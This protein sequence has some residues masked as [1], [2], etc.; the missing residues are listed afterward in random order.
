[1]EGI[2]EA[3]RCLG[4]KN[5]RCSMACPIGTEIPRIIELYKNGNIEKAGKILYE[6]NPL[7]IICSK[8]CPHENNCI[9]N[10]ILGIRGESINFPEIE[11][12]ISSNYLNNLK[13]KISQKNGE[14]IAIIG[15]GPA[16][17][18]IALILSS[19]GYDITIFEREPE[20]GG[21]LRYGIP[22]FRLEK[23]ILDK[24]KDIL[25]EFGVKIRYNELVGTTYGVDELL[26]DGYSAIFIGTGV[27]KAKAL[28]IKG[29]TLGHVK[30]AI[31]YL[32]S[33]S[34]Y[35]LGDKVVVIGAGN[36]A[37]DA[38]RTAKRNGA[39]SVVIAYRKGIE[40][41]KATKKE[42]EET[43]E[44]GVEVLLYKS[45][46]EIVDKGVILESSGNKELYECSDIIIAISQE[47][48]RNIVDSTKSEIELGSTGLVLVDEDGSTRTS[49]IFAS[50]DVVTGARTVVEA[51]AAAKVVADR[52][53]AYIKGGR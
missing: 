9:G 16:G 27:G 38:G 3:N 14:K 53:D 37:M 33:P 32:K 48:L 25:I 28:N 51:V 35:K 24:Y 44:D 23:D 1:M 29:E 39:K 50:G 12:E 52:I 31:N 15:S 6:N 26:R 18:T 11:N 46:V 4:C 5:A 42:I 19:R 20:I 45:P 13:G 17:I 43:I 34:T 47:P 49:G 21:V 7:S 40:D 2:R 8:I 36:V 41:M 10:C 30:Y 22:N